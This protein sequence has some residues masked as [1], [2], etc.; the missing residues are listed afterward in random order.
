M[1]TYVLEDICDVRQYYLSINSRKAHYNIFDCIKQKRA[2]WKGALS[3]TRKMGKGSYKKIKAVVNDISKSLPI[4]VESVSEFSYFIPEP[5]YFAEVTRLS[6]DIRK[7]LLKEKFKEIEN[8]INNQN[9]LVDELEKGEPVTP[10]MDV[11]NANIHSDGV[12]I[13]QN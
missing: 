9:L 8:L 7:P 3:S 11:Y 1:P 5:I 6:E 2:E 12:L 10:F 13:N 4:M